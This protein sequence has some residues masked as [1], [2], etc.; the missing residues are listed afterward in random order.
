ML[1]WAGLSWDEGPDIGGPYGPYRQSERLSIYGEYV[2][3]LMQGRPCLPLLVLAGAAGAHPR[4]GPEAQGAPEVRIASASVRPSRSGAPLRDTERSVVR[5]LVPDEGVT[6]FED[7]IRGRI[8]FENR[9]IDDQVLLK[10]DGFPTY[11]L[12]VVVDDH[13][14]RISARDARRGVDL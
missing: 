1:R 4:R 10:S 3:R 5:M 9:L 12:A 8:E 13:L 7:L 14:M 2:E 11:H 6:G